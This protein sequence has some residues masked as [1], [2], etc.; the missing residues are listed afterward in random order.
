MINKPID[1]KLFDSVLSQAFLDAAEEESDEIQMDE[2][3]YSAKYRR[4]ERKKY[5]KVMRAS[6]LTQENRAVRT[7]LKRAASFILVIGV[8]LSTIMLTAPSIRAEFLIWLQPFLKSTFLFHSETM[9]IHMR[10]QNT[11]SDIYPI[12]CRRLKLTKRMIPHI[13]LSNR[14]TV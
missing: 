8:I 9:L 5:N 2:I 11:F 12:I 1:D 10:R 7:V 4:E 6:C 3:K 14:L 13:M